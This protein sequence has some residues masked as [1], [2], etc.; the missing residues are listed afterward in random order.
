VKFRDARPGLVDH[1]DA[2]IAEDAAR[3]K[4]QHVAPKD[5]QI[6][7]ADCRFEDF[8]DGVGGPD[9][10]RYRPA[11]ERFLSRSLVNE[12][13][14][15]QAFSVK[16]IAASLLGDF[17]GHLVADEFLDALRSKLFESAASV[18]DS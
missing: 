1:P 4:G 8:D 3:R 7:A 2:L 10:L 16:L 11:F 5:V 18:S 6:G 14:H 13:F 17:H 15:D 12:S 9:D